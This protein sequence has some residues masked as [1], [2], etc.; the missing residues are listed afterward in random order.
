MK[1]EEANR[2]YPACDGDDHGRRVMVLENAQKKDH[3]QRTGKSNKGKSLG[4]YRVN[5]ADLE[6]D[7]ITGCLSVSSFTLTYDSV[8]YSQLQKEKNEPFLLFNISIPQ[9]HIAGVKTDRALI[10]KEVVGR[11][12]VLVNP[13]IEI[14]YTNAGKDS[15]RNVPD[16]EIYQQI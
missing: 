16:K 12:L 4:L 2:I 5:Y 9:I 10:E 7:E 15:A 8:K 3:P 13:V 14:I 11:H 6:L 1:Y